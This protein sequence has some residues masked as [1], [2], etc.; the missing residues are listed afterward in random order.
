[1]AARSDG[2]R[3]HGHI[4]FCYSQAYISV[5][6]V[7]AWIDTAV[8]QADEALGTI[9]NAECAVRD[10][11]LFGSVRSNKTIV[12]FT[13]I[14]NRLTRQTSLPHRQPTACRVTAWR[15]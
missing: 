2:M 14:A 13:P 15:C 1:M 10:F 3:S 5:V 11:R 4:K 12:S 7:S 9:I 6:F 8:A